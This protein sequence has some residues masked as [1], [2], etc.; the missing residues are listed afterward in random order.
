MGCLPEFLP[1]YQKV[2]DEKVHRRFVEAWDKG[3]PEKPGFSYMEM[4]DRILQ[5]D[6]KALYIFGEDPF[7]NL[8]SLEKLKKWST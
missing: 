6:I 2:D 3:I 1:G 4:F 8:P 7:I 5:G